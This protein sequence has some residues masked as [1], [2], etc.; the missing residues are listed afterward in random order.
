MHLQRV[1]AENPHARVP[2]LD[3]TTI[4]DISTRLNELETHVADTN[5]N[6]PATADPNE[7][8]PQLTSAVRKSMQSK[9]DA[10]TRAIR[11]YEKRATALGMQMESRM[12]D[13]DTRVKDALTLAA[14]AERSREGSAMILL[15]FLCALIVVPARVAFILGAFVLRVPLD[16]LQ[17]VK[18]WVQSITGLGGAKAKARS[19]RESDGRNNV[20]RSKRIVS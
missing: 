14:A 7:L 5:S 1:I 4:A 16:T 20:K 13:L 9:L 8:T 19:Q 6:T 15:N 12:Q 18:A 11:R 17:R 3:P 2:M 10:I